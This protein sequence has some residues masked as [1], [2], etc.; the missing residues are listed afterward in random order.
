MDHNLKA[1]EIELAVTEELIKRGYK[2][3]ITHFY[4][5]MW[6]ECDVYSI[7]KHGY[8]VEIE[9]KVSKADF[10]AD[11][12]KKHKHERLAAAVKADCRIDYAMGAPRQFYY[13]VPK[14]LI[15]IEDVPY[16]AGLLYVY[17]REATPFKKEGYGIL[18]EKGAP[19]LRAAKKVSNAQLRKLEV[20]Y[21]FHYYALLRQLANLQRERRS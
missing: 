14:G 13:A 16:Y 20:A 3:V 5:Y 4:P 11:F 12:K 10:R 15:G 2:S 7:T 6:H 1:Y 17:W 18:T 8:R 19:V 9:V 21:K